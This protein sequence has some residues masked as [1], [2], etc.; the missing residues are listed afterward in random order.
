M[1]KARNIDITFKS[2]CK[3]R[4]QIEELKALLKELFENPST[5]EEMREW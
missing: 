4:Q 3:A 5:G 2:S 1:S